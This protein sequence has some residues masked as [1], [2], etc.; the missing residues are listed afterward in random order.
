MDQFVNKKKGK[1]VNYKQMYI[2][3]MK[4]TIIIQHVVLGLCDYFISI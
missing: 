1:Y 3:D 2:G 4:F